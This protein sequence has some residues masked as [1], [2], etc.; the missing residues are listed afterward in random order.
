MWQL[1]KEPPRAGQKVVTGAW[2]EKVY[3][4]VIVCNS[5]EGNISQMEVEDFESRPHKAVSC[6]VER[7]RDKEEFRNAMSKSCHRRCL[8]AVEAGCQEEAQKKKGREEEEEE[9]TS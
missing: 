2:I 5:L 1:R 3:D 8:V 6:S 9:E 7:E 4:Y